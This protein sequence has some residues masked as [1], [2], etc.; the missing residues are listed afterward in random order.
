MRNFM[1]VTETI[2]AVLTKP[3]KFFSR[4]RGEKT[5]ETV[6]YLL[7]LNLF[8]VSMS[9]I[10]WGATYLMMPDAFGM[11][12][13]TVGNFIT[14]YIVSTAGYF[15]TA[16]VVHLFARMLG[17]KKPYAETLKAVVYGNTPRFLLGWVPFV[18]IPAFFWTFYL[19]IIGLSRLQKLSTGRAFLALL[20]IALLMIATVVLIAGFAYLWILNN[21][22]GIMRG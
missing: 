3:D 12:L 15:L 7:L 11:S 2:K 8:F 16:A 10:S 13:G 1:G 9:A 22:S 20:G 18:N 4:A 5:E 21:M 17:G 14:V 19:Q 6:N